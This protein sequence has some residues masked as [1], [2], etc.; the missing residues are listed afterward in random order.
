V[1]QNMLRWLARALN[2]ACLPLRP[3][4]EQAGLLRSFAGGVI[5]ETVTHGLRRA[6][7]ALPA[8]YVDTGDAAA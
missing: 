6:Q 8:L 5:A 4:A 3:A 1:V 7:P 2:G